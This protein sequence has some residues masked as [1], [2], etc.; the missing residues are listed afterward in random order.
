MPGLTPAPGR[1]DRRA[2]ETAHPLSD[3]SEAI[4]FRRVFGAAMPPVTGFQNGPTAISSRRREF[5]MQFFAL[6]ALRNKIVPGIPT[7][8]TLDPALAPLTVSSASQTPRS[9]IALVLCR[10]FGG[11][12]RRAARARPIPDARRP[13]QFALRYRHGGY[14][15]HRKITPG[16]SARW[17]AGFFFANGTGRRRVGCRPRSQPRRPPLPAK[18][19]CCKLFPREDGS[20]HH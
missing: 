6:M 4:A 12:K 1:F 16:Y 13:A 2:R 18:E 19:A 17:A 8:Q 20:G 3:A 11:M 9:D 15:P 14:R 5:W 10:G 7:L